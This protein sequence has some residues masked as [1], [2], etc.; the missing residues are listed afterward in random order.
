MER[1]LHTLA[2]PVDWD[3][4]TWVVRSCARLCLRTDEKRVR[5]IFN[6]FFHYE[7]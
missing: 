4:L 2:K 7:K 1:N 6:R 3:F 5:E